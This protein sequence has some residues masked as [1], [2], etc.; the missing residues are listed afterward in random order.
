MG[1]L[2]GTDRYNAD[3]SRRDILPKDSP[4][5]ICAIHSGKVKSN[6][7]GA[8]V[9]Y[10]SGLT[11]E[12][13]LSVSRRDII[14]DRREMEVSRQSPR[15]NGHLDSWT[16]RGRPEDERRR[17]P[18]LC[19]VRGWTRCAG[20]RWTGGRKGR[21]REEISGDGGGGFVSHPILVTPSFLTVG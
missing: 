7:T 10:L 2:H 15:E 17:R 8:T 9:T 18:G 19:G 4:V 6:V 16:V 13:C 1:T 20:D 3:R 11:R 21:A 5:E 14:R 12:T